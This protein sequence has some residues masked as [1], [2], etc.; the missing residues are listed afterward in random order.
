MKQNFTLCV[1]EGSYPGPSGT[2]TLVGIY[3]TLREVDFIKTVLLERSPNLIFSVVP[4]DFAPTSKSVGHFLSRKRL[5][6]E[7]NELKKSKEKEKHESKDKIDE[8][9]DISTNKSISA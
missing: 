8:K 4:T 3:P 2:S 7:M 5:E 1:I 6:Y 9:S